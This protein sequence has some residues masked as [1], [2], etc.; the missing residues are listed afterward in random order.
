MIET[1]VHLPTPDGVAHAKLFLPEGAVGAPLIVSYM[2][3][4]GLRTAMTALAAPLVAA[5]Y[6]VLQPELYWRS[7]PYAPFDAATVFSDP[8]E[9]ARVFALMNALSP[10]QV[11]ADT[12]LWLTALDSNPAVDARRV[13]VVG[14][15]MGGRMALFVAAA[16]ADR[17]VAMA[18]IHGGGLVRPTPTSPHLGAPNIRG[19]LYFGVADDDASCT[20]EDCATLGDA[21]TAA[22]VPH[23]IELYPGATHG[24]AVPDF[25]VYDAAAA[26]RQWDKVLALFAA[27]L[28]A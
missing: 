17:V 19:T 2:D 5:G 27:T 4:G 20:A 26:A 11:I 8:P 15:C 6:A 3:A 21:L 13:G 1:L 28:G 24:F 14:Y 22:G 23:E 12:A 25:T 7:G 16:L 18:S 10:D 9:R